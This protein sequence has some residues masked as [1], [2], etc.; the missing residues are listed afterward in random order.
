MIV[1]IK[2]VYN[3]YNTNFKSLIKETSEMM[4]NFST[5]RLSHQVFQKID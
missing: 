1:Y 3:P 5:L 2:N 4:A